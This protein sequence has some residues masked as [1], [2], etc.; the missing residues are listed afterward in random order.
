ML[1]KSWDGFPPCL[2][3]LGA[4]GRCGGPLT[5]TH[6][7]HEVPTVWT[8]GQILMIYI[9]IYTYYFNLSRVYVYMYI[10]IYVHMIHLHL[11]LHLHLH[12]QHHHHHHHHHHHRQI[13]INVASC[14]EKSVPPQQRRLVEKDGQS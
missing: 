11:H 14:D 9:Y 13:N 10:C 7:S 3:Q 6:G 12:P 4:L 1:N 8:S 2:L 5:V